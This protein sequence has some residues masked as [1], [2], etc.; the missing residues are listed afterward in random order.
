MEHAMTD[1]GEKLIRMPLWDLARTR[2]HFLCRCWRHLPV[3]HQGS[4]CVDADDA[5]S[6]E[7][8]SVPCLKCL[9]LEVLLI[10]ILK[11]FGIFACI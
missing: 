8:L 9:G 6:D 3:S 4:K 1:R 2:E 11:T 10:G 7:R 5:W